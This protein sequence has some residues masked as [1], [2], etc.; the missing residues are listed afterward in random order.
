MA[1]QTQG[2]RCAA[3]APDPDQPIDQ[4]AGRCLAQLG[5][6]IELIAFAIE[7]TRS[8]NRPRIEVC[9]A[10]EQRRHAVRLQGQARSAARISSR[11]RYPIQRLAS[12]LIGQFEVAKP[13][14]RKVERAVNPP[15]RSSSWRPVPSSAPKWRR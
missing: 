3:L 7:P 9:A 5:D 11:R 4:A 14:L 6:K 2:E 1:D 12:L 8:S 13:L 10:C 15:P